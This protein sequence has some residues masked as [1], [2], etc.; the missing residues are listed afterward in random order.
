MLPGYLKLPTDKDATFDD[1]ITH[2]TPKL[3]RP[4]QMNYWQNY[5][6]FFVSLT[7]AWFGK[8][9]DKKN[10][11]GYDWLP[12]IDGA[13]DVL[14]M[15]ERM[16]KGEYTGFVSQGFNPLT[17]VP[18]K[19]KVGEALSRLKYFVVIDP[20]AT[21]TSEFWKNYGEFNDVDPSKIATEV[22]RLPATSFAEDT[23][24][25]TTTSRVIQWHWK[26]GDA[27]GET[28]S[29]RQIMG[30]L[31]MKLKELYAKEGGALPAPI[32]N[33][34]WPYANPDHP[35]AEELLMEISGKAL[36][37]V[38]DPKDKK[39]VL[40]KAGE[41]VGGFGQL[42]DDGT[43]TCG[44]WIYSGCWS[45]KGNLTARRETADPSGLGQTLNWA[46][47]WPANRRI[48]YNRASCDPSGKPWDS[49]RALI[50]WNGEKWVGNDVPDMRPDAAP[51]EGVNPFIMNP[52]GVA[53][54]FSVE[55]VSDG[56]FPEHYEPF[57]TPI[58]VNPL[59]S[60]P[61]AVS[62]PAARLY[63]GDKEALGTSKEFPYVAT[64]YRLVE[65][66]HNWTKHGRLN[67]ILQPEAIA[68]IGEELA[69]EKGIANGDKVKISSN[70]GSIKVVAVVTKRIKTLDV[71]G[72]KVHTIGI[73]IHGGFK[74]AMQPAHVTNT[75]TPFVGDANVHTPEFKAFLVNIEKA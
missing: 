49:R 8:A 65:H 13:H 62:N 12:K 67:S 30:S 50:K 70:R 11:F 72:K 38:I 17:S 6:K 20:L 52:E 39:K 58:G 55:K 71:A 41:Q 59:T 53:R 5:S 48:L 32:L 16:H 9:A 28:R 40:A 60:N 36:A 25:F 1:Y 47:A 24:S 21:E 66:F 45:E 27:P 29:D 7:K 51:E 33:L 63:K 74:G 44:N 42:R 22:F 35:S 23:G 4:N 2:N 18:N 75:L 64:T 19:K 73:P 69:K 14:A 26:A 61:K 57:E 31:F 37:D 54:F 15:F 46:Y 3:L 56:P 68:E 43:T 10:N 34:A